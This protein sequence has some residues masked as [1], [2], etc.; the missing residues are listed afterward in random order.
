[1]KKL[2]LIGSLVSLLFTSC[3]LKDE[4]EDAINENIPP[5]EQEVTEDFSIPALVEGD[6]TIDPISIDISAV[7][8]E[9]DAVDNASIEE[10]SIDDLQISIATEGTTFNFLNS[11]ELFYTN[12][13]GEDE[14]LFVFDDIP[15]DATTLQ[16][17]EG[18]EIDDLEDLLEGDDFELG[19]NLDVKESFVEPIELELISNFLVQLGVNI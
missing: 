6:Q 2:I 14:T 16:L 19:F 5:V 17:P 1:M 9:I 11:L 7:K 8:E 18:E 15:V 12:S 4:V 3:D 10:V 13:E